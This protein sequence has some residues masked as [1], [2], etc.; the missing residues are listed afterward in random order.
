MSA[1]VPPLDFI[2]KL[3]SIA[4]TETIKQVNKQTD[5]LLQTV[6]TTVTDSIK[7]ATNVK[8]DDPRMKKIK[9][10]LAQVQE[11]ITKIQETIPKIQTT[12]NTVKQ[13]VNTAVAIKAAISAAQLSNPVTAAV[14]IATQL[15]LIQDATIVN[16]LES[17]KQFEQVP[18]ALTAKI[19]T[20][21]PP[22]LSALQRVEG[23]CGENTPE[24]SI[25]EN[26]LGDSD[27]RGENTPEVSIPENLL[28]DSDI[29]GENTPEVSIPENLLGDSDIQ[30]YN[31]LVDTEFY[32]EDNVNSKDLSDRSDLIQQILQ[33][34]QD[35]LQSLQEAPSLVYR[36]NGLPDPNLGKPGDY[37]VDLDTQAIIGPKVSYTT[38]I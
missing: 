6:T 26:L 11:Q 29:R 5:V 30:D 28:G 8:C 10:Q 13:I 3:P 23:A 16:A 24:V 12:I 27:I 21:I 38:W 34:Q 2:P 31:D 17:L 15:T 14:F 36:G 4:V 1:I 20:V 25:P 18:P 33:Q 9:E 35:L 22:I 7:L 19:Q 32:T 37:Y